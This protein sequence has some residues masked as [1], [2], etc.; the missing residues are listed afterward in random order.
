MEESIQKIREKLEENVE[1]NGLNNQET[2][3][4]SMLFN[5][6]INIDEKLKKYHMRT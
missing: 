6:L 1:I 5:N 3:K 4:W 2:M